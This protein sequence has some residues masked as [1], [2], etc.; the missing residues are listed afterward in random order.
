MFVCFVVL[1]L[2]ILFCSFS[3]IH[4]F[5]FS[6]P[7]RFLFGILSFSALFCIRTTILCTTRSC[8]CA[9]VCVRVKILHFCFS[10]LNIHIRQFQLF[11]ANFFLYFYF[12][13]YFAYFFI[14]ISQCVFRNEKRERNKTELWNKSNG[15]LLMAVFIICTM[16]IWKRHLFIAQCARS[17]L[18]AWNKE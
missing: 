10:H 3:F 7:I 11:F 2:Q 14:H 1:F 5:L 4:S 9:C 6:L 18:K 17:N 15:N 8:V 13:W 12:S 16:W